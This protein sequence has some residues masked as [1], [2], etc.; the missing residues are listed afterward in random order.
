MET[1]LLCSLKLIFCITVSDSKTKIPNTS[2]EIHS[3]P[4]TSQLAHSRT[5]ALDA[6]PFPNH[7]PVALQALC[8]TSAAVTQPQQT[9][10]SE[11]CFTQALISNRD[12]WWCFFPHLLYIENRT[13]DVEFQ[14]ITQSK[15]NIVSNLRA[16]QWSH[17]CT[18]KLR[19]FHWRDRKCHFLKK[20][21]DSFLPLGNATS[22]MSRHKWS[23]PCAH[24]NVKLLT[25]IASSHVQ[26]IQTLHSLLM[27]RNS[28][29]LQS[30]VPTLSH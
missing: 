28:S 15:R 10:A 11:C 30:E 27:K 6:P 5:W 23:I 12:F 7:G 17:C 26:Q 3:P 25:R 20:R 18:W 24:H 2:T 21:D 9:G 19:I 29:E 4:V 16:Q 14:D 22:S 13:Q 8:S 1:Q